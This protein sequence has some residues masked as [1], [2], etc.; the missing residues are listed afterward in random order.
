MQCIGFLRHLKDSR[1][2]DNTNDDWLDQIYLVL[3]ITTHPLN[4]RAPCLIVD[5]KVDSLLDLGPERA[6]LAGVL[7]DVEV[8]RLANV[9]RRYV[10]KAAVI[11]RTQTRAGMGG[12]EG[13]EKVAADTAAKKSW[14]FSL[15]ELRIASRFWRIAPAV[16]IME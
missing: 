4:P 10:G 15:S 7:A 1:S 2:D 11:C 12:R 9:E 6:G 14:S 3:A 8:G 16:R 13:G 5:V